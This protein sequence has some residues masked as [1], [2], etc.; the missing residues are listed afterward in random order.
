MVPEPVHPVS[1]KVQLHLRRS[2]RLAQQSS[3]LVGPA[4]PSLLIFAE[5]LMVVQREAEE[6][7]LDRGRPRDEASTHLQEKTVSFYI[8][9]IF[10]VNSTFCYLLGRNRTIMQ[11]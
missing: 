9:K 7:K 1:Q 11:S 3:T 10:G 6:G 8:N 2:S 5:L 4:G